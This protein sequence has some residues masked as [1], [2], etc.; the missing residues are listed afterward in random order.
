MTIGVALVAA[1]LTSACTDDGGPTTGAGTSSTPVTATPTSG[2]PVTAPATTSTTTDPMAG[3][4]TSPTTVP[5]T[6]G[7]P[8]ALLRAV[9]TG[10]QPGGFDRVVFEFA[11]DVLPT[12][13]VEY[14]S[15]PILEDPSGRLIPVAGAALL[16][17]HMTPASGVDLSGPTFRVVYD[18][19]DVVRDPSTTVV[20]EVARAGDF[21]A[22]AV[23]VVGLAGRAPYLVRTLSQP[24]RLVVDVRR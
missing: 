11:N 6:P 23:W 4:A 22:V 8:T 15:G 5:G 14:V 24:A 9:R 12:A 2:P 1:L 19:P 17:I 16:R 21:E 13:T 20:T 7:A 10:G 3:A 18:G